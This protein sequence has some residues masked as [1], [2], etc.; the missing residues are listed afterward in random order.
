[1]GEHRQ[2]NFGV[3]MKKIKWLLI[4]LVVIIVAVIWYVSSTQW[5]RDLSVQ[6]DGYNRK[7][8]H[9]YKIN[10]NTNRTLEDLILVIEAEYYNDGDN[11]SFKYER[12]WLPIFFPGRPSTC[13]LTNEE[14]KEEAEK[15]GI[16]IDGGIPKIV[17]IKYSK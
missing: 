11:C 3:I 1:M 16:S 7:S 9:C 4:P 5:T 12:R 15:Q 13:H 8:G 6:F 17:K 2:S 14:L 10:N